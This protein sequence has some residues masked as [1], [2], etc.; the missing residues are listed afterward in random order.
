MA[1]STDKT[2]KE[3]IIN[4]MPRSVYNAKKAAGELDPEQVYLPDAAYDDSLGLT[5]A[6]PGQI[7][8]VKT[9]QD[10]KPTEWEAVD[11]PS[12]GVEWY[13]VIDMETTENVNDLIVSADKNG[14][15]ISGYHAL[16]M[17]LCFMI[18]ADSTQTSTNGEIWVYPMA[19]DYLSS[20]LRTIQSVSAWKTTP[21]TYNY[22]YA[23]SNRAIFLSGPNSAPVFNETINN[24]FDGVRLFILKAGD[25][26]PAG[27]KVRCLVLSKGWMA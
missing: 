8:K 26:L 24:V 15:P 18:P 6:T 16:A 22:L 12:E 19:S 7:I 14:R 11:M 17:V 4:Q 5:A 21:R 2:L 27:T 10:G 13:E 1:Q 20:P 9:V 25:H 3:L 23:G